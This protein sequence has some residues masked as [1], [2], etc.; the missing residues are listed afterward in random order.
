MSHTYSQSD[1]ATDVEFQNAGEIHTVVQ[2]VIDHPMSDMATMFD[3]TFEAIG[4]LIGDG[5]IRP[6]GP[7]FSLHHRQPTETA[8]FEVGLP[9][10]GPVATLSPAEN[11]VE[12]KASTIPGG[13]IARISHIGPYDTLPEAWGAFVQAIAA[14]GKEILLPFW[15]VYVTEPTPDGDPATLRT[16]LFAL[17]QG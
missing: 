17:V 12:L 15:E 16:D 1:P 14:A 7:G 6:I 11:G 13:Q 8:T 10:D 4:P 9:V 3:S 5:S 2:K